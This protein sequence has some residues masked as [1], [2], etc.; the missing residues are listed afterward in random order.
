MYAEAEG[1][2]FKKN[3]TLSIPRYA[4]LVRS[5]ESHFGEEKVLAGDIL[6]YI[7]SAYAHF[8]PEKTE[9]IAKL[10]AVLGKVDDLAK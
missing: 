2:S 5:S 7:R 1:L 10:D 3:F 6:L 9:D 8:A 4:A